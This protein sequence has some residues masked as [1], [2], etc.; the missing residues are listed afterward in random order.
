MNQI[1]TGKFIAS[2]RKEKGLTQAQLAEKLNITDRAVSKWETGKCMPDSSIMLEL[3][4]ILGVTVNELLSGERINMNNYE[5]KVSENLI[6]LKKQN[7]NSFNIG[8]LL[9]IA[10]SA[11]I[12]IAILVCIIC[13]FANSGSFTWSPIVLVSC[14]LGWSITIPMILLG[15]K[16]IKTALIVL[17]TLILPYLFILRTIIG[18][19]EIFHIGGVMA[20]VSIAFIWVIYTLFAHFMDRKFL[21]TG[22]AFIVSLPFMI[23]INAGLWFMIGEPV[24]D[25]WDLLSAFCFAIVGV[26]CIIYDRKRKML[27]EA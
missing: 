22:I 27:T 11:S 18:V 17:T 24:V 2:C 10:F 9:A 23:I 1:E 20:A 25:I 14:L 13:D 7:E 21:A 15:K 5:E 19:K 16:G 4:S 26:A 3:C 8:K 12:G 6:E